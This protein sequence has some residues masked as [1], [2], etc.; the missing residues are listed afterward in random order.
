MR[1]II[2]HFVICMT[3]P[4]MP[5]D[6]VSITVLVDNFTDLLLV[7]NNSLIHRPLLSYGRTLFAEHGLSLLIQVTSAEKVHTILMDAGASESA[8]VS[9]AEILKV[10]LD[11]I[12]EIVIS[13]G[14]FDHIGALK[15]VLRSS[16]CRLPVHLH[17]AAFNERRK[18]R[19]DGSY[20][21]LP[22]LHK[23]D[24]THTGAILNL[25]AGPSFICNQQILITGEVE[26]TTSF[27]KGSPVLEAKEGGNF[28]VDPFR[29][30]QS[31]VLNLKHHGLIVI[32]GCAHA[33]IINSVRFAQKIS[34][35]DKV[36]AVIGGFHLSGPY[37]RNIIEPTITDMQKIAPDHIIPLH[38]TG[39]EAQTQFAKAM[40]DR[41][42]LSSV[43]T[44]FDFT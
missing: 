38:C 4:I 1:D 35:I 44:R 23:D 37:F 43:G 14:H 29:D 19:P 5:V 40:P 42:V 25:S 18:K 6:K 8:L 24:L 36:H 3:Y 16:S 34:G 21:D 13:H 11:D 20:T 22:V 33:G 31:L 41:F 17:P 39:W 32:S 15:Q 10:N 7:E 28:I 26:R 30:D 9:N 12:E 27:E 2:L